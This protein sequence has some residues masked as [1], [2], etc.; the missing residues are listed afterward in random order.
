MKG[1]ITRARR[2]QTICENHGNVTGW[3]KDKSLMP[4]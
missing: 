1:V 3:S 2:V 4:S